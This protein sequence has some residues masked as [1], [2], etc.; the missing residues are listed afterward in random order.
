MKYCNLNTILFVV[1]SMVFLGS[2]FNIVSQENEQIQRIA[3]AQALFNALQN[4]QFEAAKLIIRNAS[5]SVLDM[6][7]NKGLT[8]LMIAAFK[9]DDRTEIIDELIQRGVD[10]NS[11][12]DQGSCNGPHFLESL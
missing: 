8:M 7:V 10:V 6:T 2:G 11:K 5:H 3:V 1:F 9:S 12:S 4:K